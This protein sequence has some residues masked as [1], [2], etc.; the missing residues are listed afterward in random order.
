VL[1]GTFGGIILGILEAHG[2]HKEHDGNKGKKKKKKIFVAP[3][4][5]QKEKNWTL[6]ESMLSLSSFTESQGMLLFNLAPH[7]H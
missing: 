7:P 6:H 5:S 1:L 4:L 2:N 3:L